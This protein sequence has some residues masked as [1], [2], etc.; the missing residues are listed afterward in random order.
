MLL[1]PDLAQRSPNDFG[2]MTR[3]QSIPFKALINLSDVHRE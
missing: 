2:S 3:Q 1:T